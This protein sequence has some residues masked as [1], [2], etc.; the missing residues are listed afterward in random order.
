M[1]ISTSLQDASPQQGEPYPEGMMPPPGRTEFSFTSAT[2]ASKHSKTAPGPGMANDKTIHFSSYFLAYF[3]LAPCIDKCD[4][5]ECIAG[6]D[7][8]FLEE[9]D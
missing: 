6:R 7:I 9:N 4:K 2:T 3:I 1:I 5:H 8:K